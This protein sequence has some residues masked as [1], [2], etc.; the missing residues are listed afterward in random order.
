MLVLKSLDKRCSG[1]RGDGDVY[2]PRVWCCKGAGRTGGRSLLRF[3]L[4]VLRIFRALSP[5]LP[6]EAWGRCHAS[7]AADL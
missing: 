7:H 2:P 5:L 4:R 6:A 3:L 1:D